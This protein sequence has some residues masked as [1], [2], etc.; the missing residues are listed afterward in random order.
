MSAFKKGSSVRLKSLK[1][2]RGG[3][4]R[5]IKQ[6]VKHPSYNGYTNSYDFLLVKIA[7]TTGIKPAK[8]NSNDAVPSGG[9]AVT[10]IGYVQNDGS[11][12]ITRI[13]D[14]RYLT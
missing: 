4:V 2:N 11:S 5:M 6:L 14:K 9:Q 13:P 8:L 7:K 10:V 12:Q 1:Y 3:Q